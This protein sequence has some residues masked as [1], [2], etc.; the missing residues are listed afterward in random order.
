MYDMYL[1][2][3]YPRGL[4]ADHY[5][6]ARDPKGGADSPSSLPAEFRRGDF[7]GD[8]KDDPGRPGVS[9][10]IVDRNGRTGERDALAENVRRMKSRFGRQYAG[11]VLDGPE[12]RRP[13]SFDPA[14]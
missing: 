5:S 11:E 14:V 13:A 12:G 6:L 1:H 7:L 8:V 4:A 3:P 2:G 9:A 10:T